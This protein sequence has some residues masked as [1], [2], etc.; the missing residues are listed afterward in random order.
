[1][2]KVLISLGAL[3]LVYGVYKYYK[4]QLEILNNFDY[5]ILGLKVINANLGKVEIELD[6]EIINLSK[7]SFTLTDYYFDVYI[8]GGKVGVIKN[9]TINQLINKDGG[10]SSLPINID[11]KPS[12]FLEGN[13]ALG[14]LKS[15]KNSEITYTGYFGI[16]KGIF[17]FKNVKFDETYK[18][19]EYM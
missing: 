3:G 9:A 4:T 11:I 19:S 18:L 17:K 15:I 6:V 7:I 12:S 2:K 14:L 8:N 5:K 10:K 13:V 1:M 16:K